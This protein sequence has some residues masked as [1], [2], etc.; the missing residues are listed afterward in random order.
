MYSLFHK[1]LP[2]SSI[3]MHWISNRFYERAILYRKCIKIL[4]GY[5]F[6]PFSF[7]FSNISIFQ[8]TSD[9]LG[10]ALIKKTLL[11]KGHV[12]EATPPLN[13]FR[14]TKVVF[15]S[16]FFINI[17]VEPVLRKIVLI[18]RVISGHA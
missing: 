3:Q 16:P 6:K 14:G 18:K 4:L 17:S 5:F 2:R 11:S 12:F 10:R 7:S 13:F 15:F 1:T 8:L 9:T